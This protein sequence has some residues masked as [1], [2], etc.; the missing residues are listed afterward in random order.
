[1]AFAHKVDAGEISQEDADTFSRWVGMTGQPAFNIYILART[2]KLDH[3]SGDP[4]YQA[5]MRVLETLG[6]GNVS[7]CNKTA[8]PAEE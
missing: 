3:I 8:Q 2:G 7:F 4:G 6:L 1:M 5:T